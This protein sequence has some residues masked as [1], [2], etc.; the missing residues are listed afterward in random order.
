MEREWSSWTGV[1]KYKKIERRFEEESRQ[2][3]L[4]QVWRIAAATQV[5]E[6]DHRSSDVRD[7][8]LSGDDG[9]LHGSGSGNV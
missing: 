7:D 3:R 6:R 9:G 8:E 5:G 2:R 1:V 4:Y